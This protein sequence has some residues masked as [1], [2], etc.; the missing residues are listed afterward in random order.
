MHIQEGIS[1]RISRGQVLTSFIK[2]IKIK[3]IVK[4]LMF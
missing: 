2:G 1:E 4:Y 3:A